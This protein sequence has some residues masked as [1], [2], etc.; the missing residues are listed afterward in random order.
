MIFLST[1]CKCDALL[2]V[3][4][5]LHFFIAFAAHFF[6][7]SVTRSFKYKSDYKL[8]LCTLYTRFCSAVLPVLLD[9]SWN[10]THDTGN[11]IQDFCEFVLFALKYYKPTNSEWVSE[12]TSM[13]VFL[14]FKSYYL[15]RLLFCCKKKLFA[16]II[17]LNI[18][19][20]LAKRQPW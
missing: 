17:K 11:Y 9:I 2:N 16:S 13:V 5:V 20:S 4:F 3:H 8:S 19:F 15:L 6:R 10:N 12:M 1:N 7:P 18:Y 14:F